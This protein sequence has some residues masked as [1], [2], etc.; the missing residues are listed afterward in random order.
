VKALSLWQPWASLWACR[1]KSY[2]TRSWSTDYA[3][4]LL[5]H[6]AKRI[7]TDI[8]DAL[9]ETCKNE[10]G[11]HWAEEL[12]GGALIAVCDYVVCKP[13]DHLHVNDEEFAQGNFT[14]GRFAWDPFNMRQLDKPI[15]WRG[16]QSLFDVPDH[17]ITV[18]AAS[19][20]NRQEK[21]I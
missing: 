3:G 12:P 9:R 2:E 17:I 13:T 5:V 1:R 19:A 6:A 10:F 16:M 8:P 7:E 18:A 14:P 15:P 21:L 11:R 4:P 20:D